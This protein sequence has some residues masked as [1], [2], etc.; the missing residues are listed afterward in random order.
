MREAEIVAERELSGPE[1]AAALLLMMGKPPAARVLK[2]FDPSDLRAV[3]RA[4]AGL[5]SIPAARLDRLVE[6]FAS[7]FS[8]GADLLG[9][10][11]QA[12]SLLAGALRSEQIAD[13]LGSTP[14]DRKQ[15]D[16]WQSLAQAPDSAIIAL[17]MAERAATATYIL[18]KLDP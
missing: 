15:V 1:K 12:E 18:S 16:V 8:G 14:G 5:G 13:I 3:A 17:L 7:D 10:T 4:A 6:E 2:Q 9:D 11:G